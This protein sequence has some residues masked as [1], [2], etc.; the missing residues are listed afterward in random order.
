MDRS[1][2]KKISAKLNIGADQFVRMF[3]GCGNN[4]Q[5]TVD[6]INALY[7]NHIHNWSTDPEDIEKVLQL[8]QTSENWKL[9]LVKGDDDVKVL[10]RH[11]DQFVDY[12]EW[13]SQI[14]E[15]AKELLE[16]A[17]EDHKKK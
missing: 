8:P 1:T 6:Y 11:N 13:Q 10:I 9:V 5:K 3:E 7:N 16:R 12:Q 17:K 4:L 2:L 15:R 14:N